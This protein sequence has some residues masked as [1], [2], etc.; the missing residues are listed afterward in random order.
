MLY[1]TYVWVFAPKCIPTTGYSL[2]GSLNILVSLKFCTWKIHFSCHFIKKVL[3]RLTSCIKKGDCP[4]G[5]MWNY[6]TFHL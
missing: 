3:P 5:G 2:H 6:V 4:Q 1:N